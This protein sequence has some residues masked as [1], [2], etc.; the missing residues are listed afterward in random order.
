MAPQ[1]PTISLTIHWTNGWIPTETPKLLTEKT[2]KSCFQMINSTMTKSTWW[3]KRVAAPSRTFSW[4]NQRKKT[5]ICQPTVVH[6]NRRVSI[7]DSEWN[8]RRQLS[9]NRPRVNQV[10]KKCSK[11]PILRE[12]WPRRVWQASRLRLTKQWITGWSMG[13]ESKRKKLCLF[14]T[15][16][17][18]SEKAQ[19]LPQNRK[20]SRS[21]FF[22]LAM[23]SLITWVMVGDKA[24]SW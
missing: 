16:Q 7:K 14:I 21:F 9:K 3:S 15:T 6:P 11:L 19:M 4:T 5:R 23:S 12:G 22:R 2:S 1:A 10:T 8:R 18:A 24:L 20:I 17:K 13:Y